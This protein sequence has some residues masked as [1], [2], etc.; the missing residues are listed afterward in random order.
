MIYSDLLLVIRSAF[1]KIFFFSWTALVCVL[2]LPILIFPTNIVAI[3][4]KIWAIGV[5]KALDLICKIVIKIEGIEN[6]PSTPFIIASKHQSD[7]ETILFHFIINKPVYILKAELIKIP[8]FG[9]YLTRMGMIFIDRQSKSKALREIINKSEQVLIK[10]RPIIIFPEGTRVGLSQQVKYQVGI[11]ALYNQLPYPVI[12]V[13]LNT[14]LFW[15]KSNFIR[16][17]GICTIKILPR[18]EPGL[19]KEQF[20]SY[21]QKQIQSSTDKLMTFSEDQ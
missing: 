12:P 13:A 5:I 15:P 3:T 19:D 14:G 21:L 1:F 20:L 11:V 16:R 2:C 17:P 6:I 9:W 10:S 8:L 7:L 4:G 18:I